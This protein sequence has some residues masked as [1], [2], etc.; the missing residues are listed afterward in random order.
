MK[1]TEYLGRWSK[2]SIIA[3][4]LLLVVLV[5]IV[6]YLLGEQISAALFYLLPISISSWVVG[7]RAGFVMS[8]VSAATWISGDVVAR[9]TTLHPLI[10]FWNTLMSFGFFWIVS[11]TLSALKTSLEQEKALARIDPLTGVINRRHFEELANMEIHRSKRFMRPFTAAYIDID[12]FK[13]VNDRFGHDEGDK[14]LRHIADAMQRHLRETDIVARLGGDEFIVLLPETDYDHA[15]M[16]F[17]KM[18]EY[19][20]RLVN[21]QRWQVTFSIG[22]VTFVNPPGSVDEMI[23]NADA[24]MYSGKRGGKS[25]IRFEVL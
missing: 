24:L 20:I 19:L 8:I 7:R 1:I 6:D 14:L 17:S 13:I 12:N 5:G 11:Y 3:L 16:V 4:C 9:Q 22:V 2:I 21:K 15:N 23:K 10:H 25:M 18:N